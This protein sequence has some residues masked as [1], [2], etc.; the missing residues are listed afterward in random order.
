MG[1]DFSGHVLRAPRS[2]TTNRNTTAEMQNGV[3]RVVEQVPASYALEPA[4][5]ELVDVRADQYRA[6]ILE[7]PGTT[8]VEY[9]IWA[10]NSSNLALIDNPDWVIST[11]TGSIPSGV[12][13]V[14]NT[15]T[16]ETLEDGSDRC[17]VADEG[18]RSIGSIRAIVLV[19]GDIEYD[20]DGWVDEEDVTKGRKG[21]N[22]FH[23]VIPDV[24]DQDART[25]AVYL[26][27][28]LKFDVAT[29]TYKREG[30]IGIDLSEGL[31]T[32]LAGG[33]SQTRGDSVYSVHYT[34]SSSR[35]WWTRNDRYQTRFGWNGDNQRWEPY[36][37]GGALDLGLLEFDK[38]YRLSPMPKGLVTGNSLEG[39]GDSPDAYSMIRVGSA[40]GSE[41]STPIG[42]DL[43]GFADGAVV[44]EDRNI[45][46]H[47][48]TTTPSYAA[49][50]GRIRGEVKFNPN[51]VQENAGS[52]VWFI[53]RDFDEEADGIVG[54]LRDAP[55]GLYIAPIPNPTDFPFLSLGSRNYLTPILK[56]TDALLDATAIAEGQVGVSLSTGKLKFS[57]VDIAKSNPDKEGFSI[58]FLGAT[59]LYHG[60][61]L[62]GIP[63]PL[64][65]EI[66][67]RKITMGGVTKCI[68]KKGSSLPNEWDDTTNIYR[69]LGVSGTLDSPDNTGIIPSNPAADS[70]VRPAGDNEGDIA[71]GR[72]REVSDG[73]S[74]LI[75]FSKTKAMSVIVVD[76]ENEL[77]QAKRIPAGTAYITREKVSFGGV[78]GSRVLW[79][80][81]DNKLIKE[82]AVFFL[83]TDF[84]PS[85]YTTDGRMFSK[86]RFILRFPEIVSLYFAIDGDSYSWSSTNLDDATKAYTP[87]E[88]AADIQ[89]AITSA[90]GPANSAYA[91]NGSVVLTTNR[92]AGTV[93]IGWGSGG[94]KDLSG[95]AL[96]GFLPGWRVKRGVPCWMPDSGISFG[97]YRSPVNLDRTK[98]AAD[99]NAYAQVEDEILLEAV[100]RS[101]MVFFSQA[102]L[103]D[104]TGYD[105]GVFFNLKTVVETPDG[106]EILD[107]YLKHYDQIVHQFGEKKFS[108]AERG[109]TVQKIERETSTL[110]FG[111]AGVF[112]ESLL[113]VPG[114]NGGL[115]ISQGG[116]FEPQ[117]PDHD[118]VLPFEGQMGTAQLIRR[119][120][121]SVV[122]GGRGSTQ[123]G[124][125]T[126]VDPSARF[127]AD[128]EE[129]QVTETGEPVLNE[130][131][132]PVFLP[133]V[134][135]GYR[136][137]ITSGEAKGSYLIS[138]VL[139]P[140]ELTLSPTP[141]VSTTQPVTWEIFTGYS[142]DVY[143]PAIVADQI[144]R[145]FNH[146]PDETFKVRVLSKLG[147][148][149][150]DMTTRRL[151]A[152]I[153]AAVSKNRVISLRFGLES[154]TDTNVG[155]MVGLRKDKLG[156]IANNLLSIPEYSEA[157]FANARFELLVGTDRIQPVG[158]ASF[159]DD[160]DGGSGIEYLLEEGDDGSKGLIK[161]G[162]L[163]LSGYASADIYYVE[164][165]LE[166]TEL[167]SLS[168]EYDPE[169]GA[170][171]FSQ[172]D[173]QKYGVDTPKTAWFVERMISEDALDVSLSPTAGSAGFQ[174]PLKEFQAV[175]MSYLLADNEGRRVS[176]EETTEF[177]PVF[178]RDE[179]AERVDER[180]FR[181]NVSGREMD[182]RL[183][184]TV[185]VGPMVQNYGSDVDC[186]ITPPE[187]ASGKGVISFINKVIPDHVD[188]KVT[189]ASFEALGGERA[190]TASQ[191]PL[192]RPPFFIRQNKNNFGLRTDRRADFEPGQM[193][194]IGD[195][196]HYIRRLM[197][198]PESDLTRVDIFPPT[199][200]EVGTRSPGS[201][202]LTLISASPITTVV[203][204]DGTDPVTTTAAAGFMQPL[205]LEN[206]PFEPIASGQKTVTFRGDLTS[207]AVPGHIIE[208]AGMPFTIAQSELNQDGTRTKITTT[209]I[210]QQSL[211]V[212]DE[213]TVKLSYRPLY[214]PQVRDFIGLGEVL[215]TEPVEL[216]LFG[217]K[218]S[219]GQELPGRTLIR[220]IEY[221]LNAPSGELKLLELTQ[222]ALK[223]KQKL[224]MSHTKIRTLG[225]FVS[226]G[227]LMYPRSIFKFLF[228]TIPSGDNGY[229]DGM[230]T[231]TYTFR[232]PDTFYTRALTM[233]SYLGEAVQQAV[234][235][236]KAK[237][238]AGG[239]LA[240]AAPSGDNWD[241]GRI[242]LIAEGRNLK[243]K[244][245]AARTFLDF[246][247]TLIVG[248]EQI[249]EAVTGEYV[250]D[251]HGKFRFYQGKGL[252]YPTPGYED[253]VSGELLPRHLFTEVLSSVNPFSDQYQHYTDPLFNP[254]TS[255]VENGVIDGYGMDADAFN[256][257][258]EQQAQ[259][260]LN[261]VDDLVV[262][263]A[264]RP[265][266]RLS[267]R[268]PYFIFEPGRGMYRRMGSA[269]ALS[270]LFPTETKAFLTTYPG[271]GFDPLSGDFG[272]YTYSRVIG[273]DRKSTFRTEI[274]Q[275]GN[276]AIGPLT[277]VVASQLFARRA[278]G[279]I[280][281]YFPDGIEQGQFYKDPLDPAGDLP[282]ADLTH[283]CIVAFPQHLS[284]VE[285]HP[286]TG[287][288]DISKLVSQSDNGTVADLN[289][290]DPDLSTP[291]FEV[292]NQIM[293]G[294]PDGSLFPALDSGHTVE[295]PSGD[296]LYTG[297]FV[298]EILHGCII[299]L[300]DHEDNTIT[301]KER[302]LFGNSP[303][304]GTPAHEFGVFRGDTI[305]AIP[306]TGIPPSASY[307]DSPESAAEFTTG[308]DV[309]DVNFTSEGSLK[310]ITLPSLYDDGFWPLKEIFGQNPPEPLQTVEGPVSFVMDFQNPF[311]IPALRGEAKDDTGDY[312]IPYM[313]ATN[314]ELTLFAQLSTSLP[315][316]VSDDYP[317]EIQGIEGEV[318]GASKIGEAWDT[319]PDAHL[320][321]LTPFKEAAVFMTTESMQPKTDSGGV[322]IAD[323]REFDLLL[324]EV[325]DSEASIPSGVQ[326]ILS[327]GK[328][329]SPGEGDGTNAGFI[330]YPRFI[331]A[332]TPPPRFQVDLDEDPVADD[333]NQTGSQIR[334]EFNN[335]Y[336]F[337]NDSYPEDPQLDPPAGVKFVETD[338]DND[339]VLD[340][341]IIDFSGDV[342]LN[343]GVDIYLNDGDLHS[344]GN[345]N[346]LF[347]ADP[348]DPKFNN[349]IELKII[350]RS[351][352]N[353]TETPAGAGGSSAG[354]VMYTLT[355]TAGEIICKE[356]FTGTTNIIPIAP[357]DVEFGTRHAAYGGP[358]V[359]PLDPI[360]NRQIIIK[361]AGLLHF[362]PAIDPP[363]QWFL[364]YEETPWDGANANTFKKEM[365]YGLEFSL[366]VV[367]TGV[368][369]VASETGWIGVDRLTFN[370]VYDLRYVAVRGTKHPLEAATDLEGQLKVHEV[371]TPLGFSTINRDV[372]GGDMFTF[373]PTSTSTAPYANGG[374][375]FKLAG[376]N[377]E[378]GYI[379][380]PAF[381][382]HNDVEILGSNVRFSAMPTKVDPI[383]VGTGECA[384][385]NHSTLAS[386]SRYDDR[387]VIPNVTTGDLAD[388]QKGDLLIIDRSLSAADW[389]TTKTGT[390]VIRY[391]LG[392]ANSQFE[393]LGIN[394]V[395]ECAPEEVM[396]LGGVMLPK[397]PKVIDYDGNDYV[398]FVDSIEG[399]EFPATGRVYIV[400]SPEDFGGVDAPAKE[401][402][403]SASYTSISTIPD[404]RVK[405][406]LAEP[407]APNLFR[408]S[409]GT[410][411]SEE[412]RETLRTRSQNKYISG[413]D[414]I[415]LRIQNKA[416]LPKDNS[417]VGWHGT[418][419]VSG[420]DFAYVH[421]VRYIS[422][423]T[424]KHDLGAPHGVL[425]FYAGDAAL[426]A[427]IVSGAAGAA[428]EIGILTH[429][430]ATPWEFDPNKENPVYPSVPTR[431]DISELTDANW[432][433]LN[434]VAGGH[435]NCLIPNTKLQFAN[436][437]LS[438]NGFAAQCGVFLEPSFPRQGFDLGGA[439]PH[440]VSESHSLTADE[441]G[442][443]NF[444][445]SAVAA[446]PAQFEGVHFLVRRGRRW[447]EFNEDKENL[448]ALRYVYE[449][450]RGRVTA[451]LFT[452][453]S[454]VQTVTAQNFK[455]NWGTDNPAS[456]ITALA[457]DIWNDDR[458][459]TGTNLGAFNDPDVN[460]H[461]GDEIRLLDRNGKVVDT[462]RISS[463]VGPGQLKL[464]LPGF[465]KIAPSVGQRFEIF[466]NKAPVPHEQSMEQLLG[467][468]TYKE[469]HETHADYIS[470]TGGYA[471]ENSESYEE[472]VNKFH[473]DHP[474]T[475]ISQ[476]SGGWGGKGIRRGDILIIDP[477]PTVTQ[478]DESGRPPRG[479]QGV[480]AREVSPVPLDEHYE[481]GGTHPLDDNRGFYRVVSWDDSVDPP[482]L[483]VNP[484]HSFAGAVGFDVVFPE[485]SP[486]TEDIG[487]SVYPTVHA[488]NWV[489][490]APT[491]GSEAQNDLRPTKRRSPSDSY[492]QGYPSAN[493]KWH[494]LRPVSYRIIR[495]NRMVSEEAVDLVLTVRERMLSL[496]IKLRESLKFGN[497]YTWMKFNDAQNLMFQGFYSNDFLTDFL[498]VWNVSPYMNSRECLSILDRRF[499]IKDMQLDRLEP[500]SNSPSLANKYQGQDAGINPP[501]ET[502]PDV[503]SPYTAYTT[504]IGETVSPLLTERVDEVLDSTD[505]FR[506][507]RY[508]WLS[509]R[510]H[511]IL[512]TL[513]T[514]ERFESELPGRQV[515]QRQLALQQEAADKAG[516]Q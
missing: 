495:P 274:G 440:V 155:Q 424:P 160:P 18:G 200:N 151:V 243:D 467:L 75:L 1:F 483:N 485:S 43:T 259:L 491:A 116:I 212:S 380:V 400:L 297:V 401:A 89:A 450:R 367:T 411:V 408:W 368:G 201:D 113:G 376:L 286:T 390:W 499:W 425:E 276:P 339:G 10:Q 250:G 509:Y 296:D 313:K 386:A 464:R 321:G 66:Q 147:P 496:I 207:F 190:Y 157:R 266:F 319:P 139:S 158:V 109:D 513:P 421:G 268:F 125:A 181:Y 324:V 493:D 309:L 199:A 323:L 182:L 293:W 435:A 193:I 510:T 13:S 63:Q 46:S 237:Q 352:P 134:R 437:D 205:P 465:T 110:A 252:M 233:R 135:V 59:V 176:E 206:F 26:S 295:A 101:P 104:M 230:L 175:E 511:R 25:G 269:H 357:G 261:D 84:L 490:N 294:K 314:C 291:P 333:S 428:G 54:K 22:P 407:S 488:P 477:T 215:D 91:L 86:S 76:F 311:S 328:V 68:L 209:A 406:Q 130:D 471:P 185:R 317:D 249:N 434:S 508:V 45:P 414:T 107:Q 124:V 154:P 70:Y 188:V 327:V 264:T 127:L 183:D 50:V 210:F 161:F 191:R 57:E 184:P 33:V 246:Y 202:V 476:E 133:L 140:T 359:A 389:A 67:V 16:S 379:E 273:E 41:T 58:H 484:E 459:Y 371:K 152:D 42:K 253:A 420:N 487:Y 5:P 213:P 103:Q 2:A 159:S 229:L 358:L 436:S 282:P 344:T 165:F 235:E 277:G 179:V 507:M 473:D 62:N 417:V 131:G 6:A 384:S 330:K 504:D 395:F 8:P 469:V 112:P 256:A 255:L 180:T 303:T 336:T 251:R 111:A 187:T 449:I 23:V 224:L 402:L 142:E 452:S 462:A 164:T 120:G 211:K 24:Q 279:R 167:E 315:K 403:W 226:Q 393:G 28:A 494:S 228:N 153:E 148:V 285:Y 204:P 442:H 388:V 216:V 347:S 448:E 278:R 375:T 338:A 114:I 334:Y 123:A 506:L 466:I 72:V 332:T 39:V 500:T 289:S 348:L 196:C 480:P 121:E 356:N 479:D 361:K 316:I 64:K 409:D 366:S 53:P 132:D 444:E 350:S 49:V 432:E 81:G 222:E 430:P 446:A 346:D 245:R 136:I 220:D 502:Y 88:V 318:V 61:A 503:G 137:K 374:Y 12:L 117:D 242:G 146:L 454:G 143:D 195:S 262:L 129:P 373:L 447:H 396:G 391:A 283:P 377:P 234:K 369:S 281:G 385:K 287:Y 247:N 472:H 77:P 470:E 308:S 192:Y 354:F 96:L 429:N 410:E 512:G 100:S 275:L 478:A 221:Q 173:M 163:L 398:L 217:E 174:Q 240:P 355:F 203:D 468:V 461:S 208:I 126:F 32:F 83:Q 4:A 178:I 44:I 288:P 98:E 405:F 290:G 9:C 36:K 254:F 298:E 455:M 304:S 322:G 280:W 300:K 14:T 244:D 186:L 270:R 90:G 475:G 433:D 492:V 345:L 3:V 144:Y 7:A 34:L 463:V 343:T 260:I 360:D 82:D 331:T 263:R 431:L 515:E 501:S 239:P 65:K 341:T 460:I 413:F 514:I 20:D 87:Q 166:P 74:D 189:F 443:R 225:P 419:I 108:W 337:L 394:D 97:M 307:P 387:V 392:G 27:D 232:S 505:R 156:V 306:P 426:P 128:S 52:T 326:G 458:T 438:T 79:G 258:R 292:G 170:L 257:L 92:P 362:T 38:T 271:A 399:L 197:Y 95:A 78:T 404:G 172:T 102:P 105:E 372:N 69:G 497:Y 31:L 310:D 364:P 412:E 340:T 71:D 325:D 481:A 349:L 489:E 219:L 241:E 55:K 474:M 427:K 418:E 35:F 272:V 227:V 93:E 482:V 149:P 56:A 115:F 47:D 456:A 382:G 312:Q 118:F 168:V 85:T 171:N 162:S 218:N 231:A 516:S 351:D 423:L 11:G 106:A 236:I 301:T 335:F 416:G 94:E 457:N 397:F 194:R 60:T 40:P 363:N 439:S 51:F 302:I 150:A 370:E 73:V 145:N 381:E 30:A 453:P 80:K 48:F 214:P 445:D 486:N 141:L 267:T 441:V 329:T 37:G 299:K 284:Q 223:P 383:V 169:N 138:E 451:A 29:R 248:F 177:I 198:F 19:R 353:I 415:S 365:L 21:L 305:L 342:V 238:P 320:G 99:F 378:R 17:F 15:E 498:G 422:F 119:Y 122:V 265:T